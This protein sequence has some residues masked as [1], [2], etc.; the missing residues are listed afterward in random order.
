MANFV[1]E[2][3]P[4]EKN[5]FVGEGMCGLDSLVGEAAREPGNL[6]GEAAREPDNLVGEAARGPDNLVGEAARG[7]GSFVGEA[8][9][10]ETATFVGDGSTRWKPSFVGEAARGSLVGEGGRTGTTLVC[11]GET[12]ACGFA[13][14]GTG[15][16]GIAGGDFRIP[17]EGI[18]LGPELVRLGVSIKISGRDVSAT[19]T[20]VASVASVAGTRVASVTSATGA[21]DISVTSVGI[22]GASVEGTCFGDAIGVTSS[23]TSLAD[24]TGEFDAVTDEEGDNDWGLSVSKAWSVAGPE[25]VRPRDTKTFLLVDVMSMVMT[26]VCWES[27]EEVEVT[28]QE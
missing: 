3:N 10:L 11:K 12:G 27:S 13:G 9:R 26:R 22:M 17:N 20:R 5:N 6:V 7:P 15:G 18:A 25:V 14:G 24:K 2:G 4:R 8:G 28:A 23:E 19:G 1:G 21:R 16:Q